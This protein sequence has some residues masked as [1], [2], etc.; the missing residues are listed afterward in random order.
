MQ[1]G[2]FRGDMRL[3]ETELDIPS[4]ATRLQSPSS[5]NTYKQCP[6]KYFYQY[7]QK[8][9][10]RPSI[11]L[12][13]GSITHTIL[14][15]FWEADATHISKKSFME[16]LTYLV[17][18]LFIACWNKERQKLDELRL[19]KEELEF[20]KEETIVML[21]NWLNHMTGRMQE[22]ITRHPDKDFAEIWQRVCPQEIESEFQNDELM[23]RGFVDYIE[24][25]GDKIKIMDFKTSK[26]AKLTPEYKLQL[27]IYA[28]LYEKTHKRRPDQVGL[29]FLKHG[30][31]VIDVDD[32]L[33][34]L[35]RFEITQTHLGTRSNAISDYPKNVGPLC[36]WS[37]GHCDF[38]E[39]CFSQKKADRK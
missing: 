16:D 36:K 12:I 17:K 38:Y 14:E 26:Q 6:R 10:T 31:L 24:K 25:S 5:I 22:E 28:L 37:S 29:W 9:P 11:H 23:V 27:A 35:A 32:A 1:V 15:K 4:I 30:E 19:S 20:Y 13:R 7:I 18:G 39:T 33:L 2:W 21:A 8:L 34:E 3:L